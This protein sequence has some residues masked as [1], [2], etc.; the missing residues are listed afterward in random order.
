MTEKTAP[1]RAAMAAAK[2][3]EYNVLLAGVNDASR[4]R[5]LAL[6]I[7]SSL[8]VALGSTGAM[9]QLAKNL[10]RGDGAEGFSSSG[11]VLRPALDAFTSNAEHCAAAAAAAVVSDPSVISLFGQLFVVEKGGGG[12]GPAVAAAAAAA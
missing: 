11:S 4:C 5:R 7:E 6:E 2:A 9:E 8:T 12:S 10:N 3:V 1:E